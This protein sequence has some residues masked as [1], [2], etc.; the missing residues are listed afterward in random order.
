MNDVAADRVSAETLTDDVV[1]LVLSTEEHR[2]IVA[3]LDQ[4]IWSLRQSATS[5]ALKNLPAYTQLRSD[6]V[7]VQRSPSE[8]GPRDT[9]RDTDV[10]LPLHDDVRETI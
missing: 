2:M 7:D 9:T 4:K 8:I 10:A 6:V 3:A 5:G 1:T